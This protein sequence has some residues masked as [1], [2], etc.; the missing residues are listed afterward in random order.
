MTNILPIF[1]RMD[2]HATPQDRCALSEKAAQ[3]TLLARHLEQLLGRAADVGP[4][5]QF[6]QHYRQLL[7][8]Q[9]RLLEDVR[10]QVQA[11]EDAER[12]RSGG[13]GPP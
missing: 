6:M 11:A 4:G 2:H 13:C 3:T 8:Q 10:A 5:E 12:G 7:Q 9:E 1:F